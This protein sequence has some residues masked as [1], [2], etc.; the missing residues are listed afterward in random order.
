MTTAPNG[1]VPVLD[2]Q[3]ACATWEHRFGAWESKRSPC[4]WSQADGK[5]VLTIGTGP[6]HTKAND[7]ADAKAQVTAKLAEEQ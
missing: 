6:Y 1:G 7:C 5:D 3:G 2:D 4:A